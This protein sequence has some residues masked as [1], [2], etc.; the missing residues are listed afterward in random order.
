[1]LALLPVKVVEAPVQIAGLDAVAET[2]GSGLTATANVCAGEAPHPL[3]AVT[4]MLP[5]LGLAIAVI[6]AVVELPVHP[7]GNVHV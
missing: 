3:L 4:V 1:M 5:L 2:L 7:L 6:E